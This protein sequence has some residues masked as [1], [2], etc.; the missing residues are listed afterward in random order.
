[1]PASRAS[2]PGHGDGLFGWWL[3]SAAKSVRLW[4]V[5][6]LRPGCC[7]GCRYDRL[8][9]DWLAGVLDILADDAS[10]PA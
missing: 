2:D 9:E 3:A 7:P 8:A 5:P 6:V 10:W 1:M 4:P